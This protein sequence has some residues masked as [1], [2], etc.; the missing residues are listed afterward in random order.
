MRRVRRMLRNQ[1]AVGLPG[2]YKAEK[3]FAD[4]EMSARLQLGTFGTGVVLRGNCVS[5]GSS[6]L[7]S[8]PKH[9]CACERG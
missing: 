7:C 1:R 5:T 3:I 6:S 2:H 4:L 9:L 8:R